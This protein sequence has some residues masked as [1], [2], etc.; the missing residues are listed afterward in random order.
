MYMSVYVSLCDLICVCPP[1]FLFVSDT[2]CFLSICSIVCLSLCPF[3]FCYPQSVTTQGCTFRKHCDMVQLSLRETQNNNVYYDT[4]LFIF[5]SVC[6]SAWC[7][8]VCTVCLLR[9]V[10]SL[11]CLSTFLSV[12][13]MWPCLS[14]YLS[15]CLSQTLIIVCLS[16]CFL[17]PSA[18]MSMHLSICLSVPYHLH[19]Y[20]VY[21]SVYVPVCFR[22]LFGLRLSDLYCFGLSIMCLCVCLPTVCLFL[23]RWKRTESI[24]C[25]QCLKRLVI[26][27]SSTHEK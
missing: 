19:N 6:L 11:I 16:F 5:Q 4:F 25:I 1:I 8:F 27:F 17:Q 13:F 2:N 20:S 3:V 12:H 7:L 9:T 15:F 18:P 22:H 23:L 26:P 24:A 14:A 10:Q 21:P